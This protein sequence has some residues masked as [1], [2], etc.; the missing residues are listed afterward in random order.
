MKFGIFHELSVPRP[1]TR[2]A[3][4]DVFHNALEQTRFVDEA[5]F[6]SVW[7]VEHHFLEEYSHSSCPDMFLAACAAQTKNLRLGFG[8]ATCVPEMHHPARLAERGAFLDV[9]SNGRAEVG[10]GRSSTWNELGGF[11]ADPA[12]TKMMW[13]EYLHLLPRMWMEERLSF[14]GQFVDFPER[15]VLPKP[16]QDPH[17]PL[18]VAVTAPGTELDAA[19]RGIGCLLVSAG[20]IQ[21]NAPRFAAYRER[22]KTCR[23]A[24]AFVNNKIAAVNWLFC[25][26]DGAYAAKAMDLMLRSFSSMAGQTVELSQAYPNNAYGAIGLLGQ[27]RG[28]PS[29]EAAKAVPD[30]LCGGTPSDII[31][32]IEE[33]KSVGVDEIIFMLNSREAIPQAEVMASLD[34]FKRKVLPHF[35]KAGIEAKV[36]ENV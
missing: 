17:P 31:A 23:P 26:E 5:G 35:Q 4:R 30:G 21:K 3:E 16:I 8:I 22:I 28:D 6:N 2:F 12:Q 29:D 24:G 15:S 7:C 32:I 11:K 13:D 14:K 19:D 1:F 10:T 36:V 20:N 34:L 18:W 33:W 27:L 25:H 9:L